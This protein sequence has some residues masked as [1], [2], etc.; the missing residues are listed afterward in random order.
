MPVC[1]DMRVSISWTS[2]PR[3]VIGVTASSYQ[4]RSRRPCGLATPVAGRV[5]TDDRLLCRW[6]SGSVGVARASEQDAGAAADSSRAGAVASR[7]EP[8]QAPLATGPDVGEAVLS[9]S[10]SAAA[11]RFTPAMMLGLQGSAGNRAVAGLFAAR[12]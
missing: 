8:A 5:F 6:H 10:S 3:S 4:G 12:S 1:P 9:P 7:T 11:R 2:E